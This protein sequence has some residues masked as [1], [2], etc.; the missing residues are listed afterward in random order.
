M[1]W[2]YTLIQG[3]QTL[4]PDTAEVNLWEDAEAGDI[5]SFRLINK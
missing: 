4:P 2:H 3:L 1:N 5:F